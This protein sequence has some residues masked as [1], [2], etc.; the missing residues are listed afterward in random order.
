MASHTSWTTP[1]GGLG[2]ASYVNDTRF[3]PDLSEGIPVMG[4]I[5]GAALVNASGGP[6]EL[7]TT[8]FVEAS[9]LAYVN[10]GLFHDFPTARTGGSFWY[11]IAPSIFAASIADVYPTSQKLASHIMDAVD[12]WCG[13][14]ETMNYNFTHTA[15]DFQNGKPVDNG[16]WIEADASAGVAWLAY[17]GFIHTGNQTL[18]E[19]ASR[20]LQALENMPWNPLYEM[21]LPFGTITSARMNAEEGRRYNITRLLNWCLDASAHT[22]VG[23]GALSGTFG[24]RQYKRTIDGLI[25]SV[26]DGGGYA[27]FGNTAWFIQALSP[28]PRYDHRYADAIGK[29]LMM[30][31]INAQLFFPDRL[32]LTHQSGPGANWPP[33]NP[34]AIAYE[35]LRKCD[36]S[37][38]TSKCVSGDNFGPFGTGQNC[39][40]LGFKA[41]SGKCSSTG[42]VNGKK[43][44]ST[45]LGLYGGTFIGII[46]ATALDSGS[47][48]QFNLIA[49]DRFSK[50]SFPT[51]LVYNP[52]EHATNMTLDT[53]TMQGIV[54]LYETTSD[55]VVAKNVNVKN[56]V[57]I[58]VGP[59]QAIVLVAIPCNARIVREKSGRVV[60]GNVTIR[61][62]VPTFDSK[63]II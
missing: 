19:C 10:D 13:A 11:D 53:S 51:M 56:D 55:S 44:Y 12:K 42:Q 47:G 38:A 18:L 25:G 36:Y 52:Y 31:T 48:L 34:S 41:K 30:V 8:E 39:G 59:A 43:D 20:S 9:I 57:F 14:A 54:D 24:D 26:V 6:P 33:G 1:S 63:E 28:L 22:R 45:D 3:Y 23:W 32:A 37:R 49:N 27:F 40:D 58:K 50:T 62:P 15:F 29:W 2:V 61:F 46:G 60:V 16:K 7:R 21:L 5:L 4:A 35:G 17:I